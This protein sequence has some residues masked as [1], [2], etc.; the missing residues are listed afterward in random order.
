MNSSLAD[1]KNIYSSTSY[2]WSKIEPINW[3]YA[4]NRSLPQT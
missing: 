2:S 3:T 1:A 4:N